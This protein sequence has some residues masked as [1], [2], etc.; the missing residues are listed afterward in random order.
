M[1]VE[2]ISTQ[3]TNKLGEL[4]EIEYKNI[5]IHGTKIETNANKYNFVWKK[6]TIKFETKLQEKI[7]TLIN[8]V[9]DKSEKHYLMINGK[10]EV[11]T[12]E[13]ILVFVL[14]KKEQENIEFV[15]GKGKEKLKY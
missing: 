8:K 5:F 9:S 14:K 3:F 2:E 12:L 7:K 4:G 13:E 10:V 1:P 11:S 15:Y 6:A